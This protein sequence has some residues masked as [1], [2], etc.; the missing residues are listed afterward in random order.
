[1]RLFLLVFSDDNF[2]GY[3]QKCFDWK[4]VSIFQNMTFNVHYLIINCTIKLNPTFNVHYLIIN[5][6]IKLN[7]TCL[8][9]L[10]SVQDDAKFKL[11]FFSLPKIEYH[12]IKR[13]S[14][15]MSFRI[16]RFR[17]YTPQLLIFI[18]IRL[19]SN[20]SRYVNATSILQTCV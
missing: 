16:F 5:C 18:I 6:A 2:V 15:S 3:K 11:R 19:I 13:L 1:M 4:S 8:W 17:F 12:Y 7:P 9:L 10:S 20:A 14:D